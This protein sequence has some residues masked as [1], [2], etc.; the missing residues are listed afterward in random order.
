MNVFWGYGLF[1]D[2]SGDFVNKP[3]SA[4]TGREIMT[5]ILGHLRLEADA[6]KILETCTCIPCMMPFITSQFLCRGKGRS[7]PGG[8][9]GF[10]KPRLHRAILRTPGTTFVFTVEYSICSAQTAV[11]SLL[12]LRRT[13]L[14]VYKGDHDPRVLLR[15][16]LSL[17]N[18]D[19][20]EA[21]A[22]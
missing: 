5:K 12:S 2:K 22:F 15:T 13:P 10:K 4:C 7:P 17:H 19:V 20:Q 18:R 21:F 6:G 11:Y 1:V 9:Q 3:M 16:F 14:P 8:P